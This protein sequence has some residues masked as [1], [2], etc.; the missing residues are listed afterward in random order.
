MIYFLLKERLPVW[1]IKFHLYS[2]HG[3]LFDTSV[4]TIVAHLRV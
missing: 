2:R 4:Q 1:L 3:N